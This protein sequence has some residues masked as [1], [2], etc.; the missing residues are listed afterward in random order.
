MPMLEKLIIQE[1]SILPKKRVYTSIWEY[2]VCKAILESIEDQNPVSNTG[3]APIHCAAD[4]GHL[5]I[6]RLFLDNGADR[7]SIYFGRTPIEIA[8]S[9]GH[10]RAC[11]LLM[12]NLQDFVSFPKII[13]NNNVNNSTAKVIILVG[14]L[15]LGVLVLA[16][17]LTHMIT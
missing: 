16:V 5:E 12:S 4:S 7:R 9:K 15:V 17:F 14:L 11:L 8:A 6:L 3:C 1:Y 10:F 13:W 2:R